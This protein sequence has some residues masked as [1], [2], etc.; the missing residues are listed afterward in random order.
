MRIQVHLTV[1][2]SVWR[3]C[4]DMRVDTKWVSGMVDSN[5][6]TAIYSIG[7]IN[8]NRQIYYCF[9]YICICHRVLRI[10]N[11]CCRTSALRNNYPRY[12]VDYIDTFAPVRGACRHFVPKPDHQHQPTLSLS[13]LIVTVFFRAQTFHQPPRSTKTWVATL[14]A[15]MCCLRCWICASIL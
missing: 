2:P 4:W 7:E 12:G 6:G 14:R 9:G 5:H 1:F 8:R 15:W 3:H 11:A 10:T 13:F